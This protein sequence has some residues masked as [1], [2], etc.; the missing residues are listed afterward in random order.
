MAIIVVGIFIAVVCYFLS[1]Q[2]RLKEQIS[3]AYRDGFSDACNIREPNYDYLRPLQ[4]GMLKDQIELGLSDG[5]NYQSTQLYKLGWDESKKRLDWIISIC[6]DVF[7][8]YGISIHSLDDLFSFFK[9]HNKS[10]S[11]E[12][13]CPM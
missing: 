10:R 9:A 2:Q 5:F 12:P 6:G 13:L 1:Q 7:N 3:R 4:S 8:E 11:D